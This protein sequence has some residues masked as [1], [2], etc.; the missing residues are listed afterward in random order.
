MKLDLHKAKKKE[1]AEQVMVRRNTFLW[2][3]I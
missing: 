2:E 1:Y 3:M